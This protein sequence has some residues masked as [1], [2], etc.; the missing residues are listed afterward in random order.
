MLMQISS[1]QLRVLQLLLRCQ[2]LQLLA[3][4]LL[5]QLRYELPVA[6]I[7][8]TQLRKFDTH[9]LLVRGGGGMAMTV[10]LLSLLQIVSLHSTLFSFHDL[11]EPIIHKP[12][13]IYLQDMCS[14]ALPLLP[15]TELL[16]ILDNNPDVPQSDLTTLTDSK[17]DKVLY[18][19]ILQL[20]N[21]K[22][23]HQFE[24]Y[25]MF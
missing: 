2:L 14:A 3:W 23:I 21:D 17:S 15:V 12:N 19:F 6:F 9:F 7:L 10:L 22:P 5:I 24:F 4:L 25:N 18:N 8:Q 13:H 11:V 1:L 20:S 16:L